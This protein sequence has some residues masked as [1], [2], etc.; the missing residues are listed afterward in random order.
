MR[1]L[2]GNG[3]ARLLYS[4]GQCTQLRQDL[5]PQ[6]GLIDQ[7]TSLRADGEIGGGSHADTAFGQITVMLY[8]CL[9]RRAIDAHA[10][11]RAGFDE[12]IAQRNR[13]DLYRIEW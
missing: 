5:R 4:L 10:F 7:R 12:S 9:G 11:I 1:D 3:G 2:S 8:Q 6:P 13:S